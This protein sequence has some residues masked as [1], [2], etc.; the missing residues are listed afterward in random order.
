MLAFCNLSNWESHDL[1]S[2]S[3]SS[4]RIIANEKSSRPTQPSASGEVQQWEMSWAPLGGVVLQT[5]MPWERLEDI[6]LSKCGRH[7]E[8]GRDLCPT[9]MTL[10]ISACLQP[11]SAAWEVSPR[12]SIKIISLSLQAGSG[13]V[14]KHHGDRCI[15]SIHVDPAQAC[16]HLLSIRFNLSDNLTNEI[17]YPLSNEA[18]LGF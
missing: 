4:V 17:E 11:Q 8:D 18:K 15:S 3:V 1:R 9:Y 2:H 5:V 7:G 6:S 13:I 14:F 10:V 12:M 16:G